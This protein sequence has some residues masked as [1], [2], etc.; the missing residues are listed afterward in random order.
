MSFVRIDTRDEVALVTID[1]PKANAFSPELVS[2][3]SAAF[4]EVETAR[5]IVLGSALPGIFSAGWDLPLLVDSGP[6]RDGG[7]RRRLLRP[8]PADL[9]RRTSGH[10]GASRPRHRGRSHRRHGGGRADRGGRKG[11]V[12]ALRSDPRRLGAAVPDG[13]VPARPGR[14][15]DGAAGG[16][17]GEP[18]RRGG[19]R[20]RPARSRGARGGARRA[21]VRAG[22][23]AR[24]PLEPGPRRDQAALA[25]GGSG[26]L[27]P[28]ARSRPL[29]RFLVLEDA[30]FRIRDMVA[31]LSSRA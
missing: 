2:E 14:A 7:I 4:V 13:A 17:G 24:R 22:A 5:A 19:P 16:D 10:R 27:R 31:R 6:G 29:P 23:R 3:L 1:R 12:R 20:D 25:G 30:R 26:A 21:G 8:R 15:A 9:H 18:D 28:G 11:Q